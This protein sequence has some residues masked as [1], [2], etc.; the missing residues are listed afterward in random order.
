MEGHA[1]AVLCLTVASRFVYSGSADNTAKCWLI[2]SGDCVKTYLGH[3]HSVN[4]IIF[5]HGMCEF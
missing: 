5:H 1:D 3:Q 2:E 4:C